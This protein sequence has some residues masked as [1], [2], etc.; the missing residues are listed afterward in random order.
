MWAPPAGLGRQHQSIL[1]CALLLQT[2][3]FIINS[4]PIV[5]FGPFCYGPQSEFLSISYWADRPR[6][7][8][9]FYKNASMSHC[10]CAI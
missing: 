1:L 7:S 8:K 3:S 6:M 9:P 10:S 5:R 4:K 2:S